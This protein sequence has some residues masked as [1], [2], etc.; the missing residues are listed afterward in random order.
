MAFKLSTTAPENAIA[1][2]NGRIYTVDESQPWAEAFIV[3]PSG[4]FAAVGV[5]R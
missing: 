2:L 1:Y 4:T 5:D 3:S